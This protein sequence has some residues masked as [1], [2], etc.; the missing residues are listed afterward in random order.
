M[1]EK[2]P[3]WD[4]QEKG[5]RTNPAKTKH[6]LEPTYCRHCLQNFSVL[7]SRWLSYT[8]ILLKYKM[9]SFMEA[10]VTWFSH[11]SSRIG[12]LRQPSANTLF[13]FRKILTDWSGKADIIPDGSKITH[14]LTALVYKKKQKPRKKTRNQTKTN[15][16]KKPLQNQ[17]NKLTPR[18]TGKI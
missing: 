14:G 4:H 5:K 6:S 10:L 18:K 11:L 12:L 7:C 2:G 9:H 16:P 8:K 3:T 17:N 15:Q 1:Q 13:L